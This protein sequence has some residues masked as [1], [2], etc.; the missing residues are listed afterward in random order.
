[1]FV[2]DKYTPEPTN[3]T[4]THSHTHIY[5]MHAHTPH[6]QTAWLTYSRN[7]Q[8]GL[9]GQMLSLLKPWIKQT[10]IQIQIHILLLLHTKCI[11]AHISKQTRWHSVTQLCHFVVYFCLKQKINKTFVLCSCSKLQLA[12]CPPIAEVQN[13][14]T[15][16]WKVQRYTKLKDL[17]IFLTQWSV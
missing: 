10:W 1:M 12:R 14:K 4:Q 9:C 8:P 5:S 16:S 6:V 3:C 7:T 2:T 17:S 13:S 15:S 11:N